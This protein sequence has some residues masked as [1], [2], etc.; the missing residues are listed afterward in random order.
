M[1]CGGCA[2][3]VTQA[4]KG[5]TGVSEVDVSLAAGE[6]TVRYD[7]QQAS[8]EQLKSAVQ[9]AGYGVEAAAGVQ[10]PQAKRGCGCGC[11]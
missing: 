8:P 11:G 7:E 2:N 6:A 5:I 3:T 10:K 9:D 1:T 4:L